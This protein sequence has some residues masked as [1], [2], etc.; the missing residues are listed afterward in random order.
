VALVQ[1]RLL[2]AILGIIARQL[3]KEL[4]SREMSQTV[5][6]SRFSCGVHRLECTLKS[7]SPKWLLGITPSLSVIVVVIVIYV[8][9]SSRG[10]RLTALS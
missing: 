8:T 3:K 1:A 7:H 5:K 9:C 2:R 4:S 6:I 10:S